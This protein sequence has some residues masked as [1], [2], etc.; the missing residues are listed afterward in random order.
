MDHLGLVQDEL[1]GRFEEEELKESVQN[2]LHHLVVLLFSA[3]QVLKDLDQATLGDEIGYFIR[4][5]DRAHKHDELKQDIVLGV[6]IDEVD[7]QEFKEISPLEKFLPLVTLN[8]DQ[9]AKELNHQVSVFTA[10]L[11]HEDVMLQMLN[12]RFLSLRIELRDIT[13]ALEQ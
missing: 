2:L 11:N 8:P 10:L 12:E 1:A 9:R 3:K 6:A 4:A 13:D 5:A 7:M